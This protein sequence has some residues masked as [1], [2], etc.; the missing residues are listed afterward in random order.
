MGTVTTNDHADSEEEDYEV[1]NEVPVL[2]IAVAAAL[3]LVPVALCV[4]MSLVS[5]KCPNSKLGRK[6]NACKAGRA[7]TE[8]Q[9]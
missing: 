4:T 5:R 7:L 6:L 3:I 1:K 8:E 2:G 9:M